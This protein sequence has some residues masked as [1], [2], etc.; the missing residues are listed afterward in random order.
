MDCAP[1]KQAL[2]GHCNEWTKKFY[3]LLN[4]MASSELDALYELFKSNLEKV[5]ATPSSLEMLSIAFYYI[6]DV[7]ACIFWSDC[8]NGSDFS[9]SNILYFSRSARATKIVG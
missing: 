3:N 7:C 1:L 9:S 5:K 8:C 2:T 4:T 6:G